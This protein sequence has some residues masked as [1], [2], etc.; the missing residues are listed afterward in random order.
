MLE[1]PFYRNIQ[2]S[3][4]F[5]P[6]PHS[7]NRQNVHQMKWYSA[8]RCSQCIHSHQQENSPIDR[9]LLDLDWNCNEIKFQIIV[10]AIHDFPL[11]FAFMP[12]RE[13]QSVELRR[14]G[15]GRGRA[16]EE[17]YTTNWNEMIAN[18]ENIMIAYRLKPPC[19]QHQHIKI[20]M[21]HIRMPYHHSDINSE[22]HG[23]HLH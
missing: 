7:P 3:N 10:S 6:L 18:W 8:I 13:L 2:A 23:N 16:G 20:N 15:D 14:R 21:Y 11:Q 1:K 5:S 19:E 12:F 17:N 4:C 22:W 9:S